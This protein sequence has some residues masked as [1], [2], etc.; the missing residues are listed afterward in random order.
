MWNC[1]VV[2]LVHVV[3]HLRSRP[4]SHS[5]LHVSYLEY[6]TSRTY[7]RLCKVEAMQV[8]SLLHKFLVVTLGTNQVKG[9]HL[10]KQERE[11]IL[12]N[13]LIKRV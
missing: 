2:Y 13:K 11:V 3:A 1:S 9:H 12:K 7:P 5:L 4:V 10:R 6:G 8:I